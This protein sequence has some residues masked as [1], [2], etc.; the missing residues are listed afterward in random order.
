[1]PT[2][3][4]WSVVVAAIA[5]W[6][7]QEQAKLVVYLLAENKVRQFRSM[8]DRN[9]ERHLPATAILA[10]GWAGITSAGYLD[11]TRP[12]RRR[13]A[14]LTGGRCPPREAGASPGRGR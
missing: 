1:M 12:A 7:N 6:Q 13:Q 8:I 9:P 14:P 11:M 3:T 5:G 4:P 10:H 2:L